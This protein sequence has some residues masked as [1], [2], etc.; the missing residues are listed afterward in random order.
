[1]W[2]CQNPF[3][4]FEKRSKKFRQ[5]HYGSIGLRKVSV[6]KVSIFAAGDFEQVVAELS[7]YR[8]LDLVDVCAEDDFV[9]LGDH[10]AGAELTKI[11][12]L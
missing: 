10:L 8:P 1:M 4:P 11:T 12:T 5:I 2:T 3:C 9:E 6:L 7:L